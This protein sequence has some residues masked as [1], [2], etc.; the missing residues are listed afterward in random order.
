L[1]PASSVLMHVFLL[2]L[3]PEPP[4][5]I[6]QLLGSIAPWLPAVLFPRLSNYT[7]KKMTNRSSAGNVGL[8]TTENSSNDLDTQ[9]CALPT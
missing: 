5:V 7:G 1:S 3:S 9:K 4:A 6:F 2:S 8:L